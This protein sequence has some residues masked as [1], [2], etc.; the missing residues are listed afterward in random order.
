[1]SG[2]SF[3]QA[4]VG[5]LPL[6]KAQAGVSARRALGVAETEALGTWAQT[7]PEPLPSSL[8]VQVH[9]SSR[10][11]KED[12]PASVRCCRCMWDG[13]WPYLVGGRV[14]REYKTPQAMILEEPEQYAQLGDPCCQ[15]TDESHKSHMGSEGTR[16]G[17]VWLQGCC[18]KPRAPVRT[19]WESHCPRW[20][21]FV[22]ML[23]G[24][25]LPTVTSRRGLWVAFID[26]AT[27][28]GPY[29][30]DRI[31]L[32]LHPEHLREREV[33]PTPSGPQ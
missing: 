8:P 10:P 29:L 12:P 14:D 15:N 3:P 9:L 20:L 27:D 11:L 28:P 13:G 5:Y 25:M 7:R 23:T 24:H 33:S 18:G 4:Q 21:L 30:L 32:P 16:L 19:G 6:G 1:M 22:P 26:S 2:T 17:A 31:M